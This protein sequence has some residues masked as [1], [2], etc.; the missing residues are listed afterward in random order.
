MLCVSILDL[1]KNEMIIK[2]LVCGNIVTFILLR[3]FSTSQA[4]GDHAIFISRSIQVFLH[5]V[6]TCLKI[7]KYIKVIHIGKINEGA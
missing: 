6:R 7:V 3:I 1:M 2:M 4:H 5:L